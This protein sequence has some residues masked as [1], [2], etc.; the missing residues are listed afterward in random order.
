M[1]LSAH[2]F[3]LPLRHTFRISRGAVDTQST[4]IV[5]LEQDGCRGYGEATT[6]DYYGYTLENMAE[7]LRRAEPIIAGDCC[8]DPVKLFDELESLLHDN[9]FALCALDQAAYDLWGKLRASPVYQLWGL[10]DRPIPDSN[11]TIG[12]ADIDE[13][14]EKM[15]EFAEWPI[16]KIKLGTD[17]DVEIVRALR[18]HTKA[19]F[20]VDANGAWTAAQAIEYSHPLKELG[21]EFIEQPLHADDL[22]EM[23]RVFNESALPVIAD[24]NCIVPADVANCVGHFHGVNIKLVKC[25][26]LTPARRM[27][28]EARTLG[29]KVMVGCMTESTVGIS[30]IAQLL[31]LL[32]YVDMDGAALL[33]SDIAKGVEVIN[34]TCRFA[35]A[36]GSG[37]E[38]IA[39]GVSL[40]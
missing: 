14:V 26:G 9:P 28:A 30:A 22:A 31:P 19:T 11:Y 3:E 36:A 17:D 5:T 25:G 13:M 27:I 23:P 7:A 38:L 32:D 4:L 8:E 15:Q 20:R 10:T 21:V 39:A 35:D 18:Q 33:S 29:L 2:A 24:E 12:I 6:N 1:K 34:G 16:Y 37:V 40:L